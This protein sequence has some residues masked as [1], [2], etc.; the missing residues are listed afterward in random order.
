MRRGRNW[1]SPS[2]SSA[3]SN[4]AGRTR[5]TM[6]CSTRPGP[7]SRTATSSGCPAPTTR[8]SRQGPRLPDSPTATDELIRQMYEAPPDRF[9]ATRA[10]AI[11]DA[12]K[13][14]DKDTARRLAALRKPTVAA[15]LVNLLAL[16]RPE[17]IDELVELSTALRTA[18]RSL[19]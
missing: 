17:L 14:G 11:A 7:K 2:T 9:V 15:W 16:R 5:C 6:H 18:Q 8:T 12:R 1:P 3:R 13:A 4:P 19:K 10:A